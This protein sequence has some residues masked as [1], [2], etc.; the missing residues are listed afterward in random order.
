[1]P[2][3]IAHSF[4]AILLTRLFKIHKLDDRDRLRL[5][6]W[7]FFFSFAPDLDIIPGILWN[8]FSS[9]HNQWTHSIVWCL[10]FC[11][12]ASS[13]LHHLLKKPGLFTT[14]CI[15]C[16]AS[17]IHLLMDWATYGR[18]V[19]LF[20]P[21]SQERYIMQPSVF[22]GVRWSEGFFS[23]SHLMTLLNEFLV[24]ATVC[25]AWALLTRRSWRKST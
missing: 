16:S 19:M 14:L 12:I 20:W 3:P 11:L 23:R 13:C 25:A 21:F 2:S 18:G 5:W 1:V 7:C 4:A 9:F 17:G 6:F 8:D 15:A 22:V 10:F 24:I